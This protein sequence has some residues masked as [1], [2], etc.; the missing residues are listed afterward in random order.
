MLINPETGLAAGEPEIVKSNLTTVEDFVLDKDLNIFTALFEANQFVRVDGKTGE[1]LV[2]AGNEDSAQYKWAASVR[3]GRLKT[4]NGDL[5]ATINGG[6]LEPDN[7]GGALFRI[8]LKDL[9][10]V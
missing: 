9:A 1:V 3:F 6:F 2:L 4:D 10:V 7:V 5:Y 8:K